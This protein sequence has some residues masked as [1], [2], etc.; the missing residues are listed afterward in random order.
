MF[1]LIV[2]GLIGGA[3][4]W[5]YR[6]QLAAKF[7]KSTRPLREKAADTL[8]TIEKQSEVLLDRAKPQIASTLRAG[9]EA[10]RPSEPAAASQQQP[11]EGVR[12]TT[13]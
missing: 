12:R 10:I 7:D 5:F 11:G 1:G 6:D 3:V 2:G 9:R 13:V 4:V 8:E